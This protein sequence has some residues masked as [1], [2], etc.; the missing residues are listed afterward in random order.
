MN[1][2]IWRRYAS[3]DVPARCGRKMLLQSHPF[4]NIII[5]LARYFAEKNGLQ[6]IRIPQPVEETYADLVISIAH[7][8]HS[9]KPSVEYTARERF[10]I[11][12]IDCEFLPGKKEIGAD[13]LLF[14]RHNFIR[15]Y[16]IKVQIMPVK[17]INHQ[18]EK[19]NGDEV[20]EVLIDIH[21]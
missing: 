7:L 8:H 6:F 17:E 21:D 3:E 13:H 16:L 9:R 1:L 14:I 11:P 4:H 12:V 20:D 2:L 10:N 19:D 18:Q 5:N 15:N